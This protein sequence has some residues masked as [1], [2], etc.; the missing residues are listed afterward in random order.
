[1]YI[2]KD[3]N[4]SSRQLIG[5]SD[6]SE[7]AYAGVV[8][9]K[10]TD[11]TGNCHITLV[12]SKTKVVPIKRLSIPRLELSRAVVLAQHVRKIL[13]VPLSDVRA[14]T[15]S[16]RPS[17]ATE[18]QK[19]STQFHLRTGTTSLPMTPVDCASRGLSPL[20]LI[21]WWEGSPWLKLSQA[22]WP[23]VEKMD[24]HIPVEEHGI[25]LSRRSSRLSLSI[26]TQSSH[27]LSE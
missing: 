16:F 6:T 10:V 3:F 12:I 18:F 20:E 19:L 21:L 24:K 25:C 7:D 13:G 15:D 11:T 4:V 5:F 26:N 2:P 17:S 1:M 8:Y 23:T 14:R 27:V 22:Q 9:M